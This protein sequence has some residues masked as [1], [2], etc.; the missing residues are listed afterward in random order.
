[1][2]TPVLFANDVLSVLSDFTYLP[3]VKGRQFKTSKDIVNVMCT[4]CFKAF[5]LLPFS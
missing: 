5:F 4:T 1:M 3:K 2:G